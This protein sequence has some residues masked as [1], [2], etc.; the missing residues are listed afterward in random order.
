M[1]RSRSKALRSPSS[2]LPKASTP[3][4]LTRTVTSLAAAAAART[5]AGS[6]MS[7]VRVRTRGSAATSAAIVPGAR[8]VA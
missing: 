4:L 1:R 6:V 2:A 5:L 3:A 8:E 7:S